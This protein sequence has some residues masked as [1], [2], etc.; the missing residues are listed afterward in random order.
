M[1]DAALLA[2]ALVAAT[3]GMACLALTIGAHWR[4]WFH[5]QPQPRALRF[6]LRL[7]GAALLGLSFAFCAAADPASMAVLV[8]TM[9]LTVGAALVVGALTLSA[10]ATRRRSNRVTY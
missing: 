6:G 10:R 3:A 5:E 7:A 2:L 9:L 8:W 4:Q 1:S